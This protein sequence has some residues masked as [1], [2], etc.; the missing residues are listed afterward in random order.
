MSLKK[1]VNILA[2]MGVFDGHITGMIEI[3]K[4]L[5][6]LGHNI[7]CYVL[8]Q[9]KDRLKNIK[10]KL[11]VYSL[12][13]I[14]LP[15]KAPKKAINNHKFGLS[16]DAILSDVIKS[17]EKYDYLL[18]DS[19]F[20]GNEINKL[21]KIPIVISVYVFPL[22][23]ETPY[24]N[25]GEK[26]RFSSIKPVNQKFNLIIR[27][28]IQVH[29][30]GDTKYKLML[31]SKLFHPESKAIDDSF[32]FI[33]PSFEERPLDNNFTFKKDETKKLIYVSLGTIFNSNID[34]YKQF[35]KAFKNSKDF[36]VLMSIGKYFQ[37]KDL[38]DLPDNIFVFNYLYLYFLG[39]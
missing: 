7:T 37:I 28:F 19:F 24:V 8:D 2:L 35:I 29:Y 10:S 39:Y 18:I 4:E 31:T 5:E 20:D 25:H 33:G 1:Q 21:F 6:D 23:E 22:G 15:S 13:P 34:F 14:K 12:P 11:K 9:Y 17:N 3:I 26:N 30:A 27:D 16:Y 36:Q 38:G 32:Y